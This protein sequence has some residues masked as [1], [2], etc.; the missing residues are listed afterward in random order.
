MINIQGKWAELWDDQLRYSLCI[1]LCTRKVSYFAYTILVSLS[2]L[3][4]FGR[5]KGLCGVLPVI[6]GKEYDDLFTDRIV[7][8]GTVCLYTIFTNNMQYE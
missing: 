4:F 6:R 7:Q 2:E 1:Y 8:F 3:S 5:G